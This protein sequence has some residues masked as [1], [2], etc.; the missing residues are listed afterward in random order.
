MKKASLIII[1]GIYLLITSLS[2]ITV[3]ANDK[4]ESVIYEMSSYENEICAEIKGTELK[5]YYRNYNGYVQY[6]RWDCT[7]GRWYDSDWITIGKA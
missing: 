2:G 5:I 7:H 6:K 4:S 1:T 3:L